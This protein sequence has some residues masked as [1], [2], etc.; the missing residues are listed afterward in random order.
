MAGKKVMIPFPTPGSPPKEGTE[1]A[2]EQSTE[3][4]SEVKLED[5]TVFRLKATVMSAV[6]IEGEYD[7]AGNPMYALRAQP[8]I[9]VVE[10]PEHLKRLPRDS[11][12][13]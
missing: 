8:V 12:I 11:K 4:W 2:V 9:D 7:P 6:R 3:R 10:I 1:V 5:G 13:N